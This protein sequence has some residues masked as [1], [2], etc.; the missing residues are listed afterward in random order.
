MGFSE[1]WWSVVISSTS[2]LSCR[3]SVCDDVARV[4]NHAW[5]LELVE[6]LGIDDRYAI[7]NMAANIVGMKEMKPQGELDQR[8]RRCR[9]FWNACMRLETQDRG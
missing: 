8:L 7:V 9:Q 3:T 2:I 1:N 6:G 4:D 5:F